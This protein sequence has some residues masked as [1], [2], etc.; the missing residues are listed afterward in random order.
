MPPLLI[1][2]RFRDEPVICRV[3]ALRRA[4]MAQRASPTVQK[5]R[6]HR[7]GL[8]WNA[9]WNKHYVPPEALPLKPFSSAARTDELG[10]EQRAGVGDDLDRAVLGELEPYAVGEVGLT[11]GQ[12]FRPV[13]RHEGEG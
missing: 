5:L 1:P 2:I 12:R 7:I 8:N 3:G 10:V 4:G 13:A 9:T 11:G 6:G